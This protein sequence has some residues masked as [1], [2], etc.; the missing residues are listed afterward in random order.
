[1]GDGFLR[2]RRWLVATQG[3]MMARSTDE[4]SAR[5]RAHHDPLLSQ[6]R[7]PVIVA[8]SFM[9]ALDSTFALAG[10]ETQLELNKRSVVQFC[11]KAFNQKDFDE[12][13]CIL[14]RNSSNTI[15]LRPA[16]EPRISKV[17]SALSELPAQQVPAVPFRE[18][19]GDRRGRPC[20]DSLTWRERTG[21]AGAS[22][23]RYLSA[24]AR[25]DCRTL[26]RGNSPNPRA[27]F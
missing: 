10:D 23:Y 18:P 9:L 3:A 2:I 16:T 25:Q 6:G 20:G 13:R 19:A 8:A 1:M 4:T 12:R 7:T 15:R 24:R 22:D 14:G 17:S 27:F 26:R 21:N 11:E 5:K